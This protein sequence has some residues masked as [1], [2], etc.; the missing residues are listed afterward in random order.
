MA[1]R[2]PRSRVIFLHSLGNSLFGNILQPA[3]DGKRDVLADRR[4]HS[5]LEVVAAPMHIGRDA[6][7]SGVPFRSA[8]SFFSTP[9]TPCPSAFTF[10]TTWAASWPFGYDRAAPFSDVDPVEVQLSA[11]STSSSLGVGSTTR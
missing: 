5:H 4:A 3:V 2:L 8:F 11:A 6:Q 1:T 9:A 10:P 7:Q